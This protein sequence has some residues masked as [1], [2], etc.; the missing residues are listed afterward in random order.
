MSR[1]SPFKDT[2]WFAA[3]VP[4]APTTEVEGCVA[5]DVCVVCC[6][7]AVVDRGAKIRLCRFDKYDF[8]RASDRAVRLDAGVLERRRKRSARRGR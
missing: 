4:A 6:G 7:I 1:F 2:L 8:I 3:A 5:A